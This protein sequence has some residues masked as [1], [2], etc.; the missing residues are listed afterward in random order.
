MPSPVPARIPNGTASQGDH[1]LAHEVQ[2]NQLRGTAFLKMTGHCVA[3][4]P[5]QTIQ[6]VRLGK[7]A[8]P[9]GAGDI[10]PLRGLVYDKNE[11]VHALNTSTEKSTTLLPGSPAGAAPADTEAQHP[12]A[13]AD[14]R[15]V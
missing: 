4:L 14:G 6:I 9:Q 10:S 11:F 7:N 1:F 12:P 3:H 15:Q 5:V 8:F 2:T 13:C